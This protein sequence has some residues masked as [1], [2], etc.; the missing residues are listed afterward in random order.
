MIGRY[1]TL[2]RQGLTARAAFAMAGLDRHV[3]R[4]LHIA[5]YLFVL[6]VL[7]YILMAQEAAATQR[8]VVA[9]SEQA[10]Y[11]S[12]LETTLAKCLTAGDNPLMIGDELVFCGMARTG[13]RK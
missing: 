11:V 10:T 3:G 2:R 9:L 6:G 4:V 13:V 12:A 8:K 1:W 5:G 7:A